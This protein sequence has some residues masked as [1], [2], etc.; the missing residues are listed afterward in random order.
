MVWREG[1]ANTRPS[2]NLSQL[3][4]Q[5]DGKMMALFGWS[6]PSYL[7]GGW[8]WFGARGLEPVNEAQVYFEAWLAVDLVCVSCLFV[9]LSLFFPLGR[10]KIAFYLN[11]QSSKMPRFQI[12]SSNTFSRK[13]LHNTY[14]FLTF[15]SEQHCRRRP[16]RRKTTPHKAK[17]ATFSFQS[18]P[19]ISAPMSFA[20]SISVVVVPACVVWKL[21]VPFPTQG[22]LPKWVELGEDLRRVHSLTVFFF[23]VRWMLCHFPN[24]VATAMLKEGHMAI[25]ELF[26]FL[27]CPA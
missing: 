17:G 15:P 26:L 19:K 20:L 22:L 5:V 7:T 2:G 14:T 10:M 21:F 1:C 25:D 6:G 27:F 11:F 24:K 9:I 3:F 16:N 18:S 12:T 23:S 4:G 13:N 8:P